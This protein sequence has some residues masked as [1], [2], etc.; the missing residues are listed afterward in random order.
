MAQYSATISQSTF[1]F[2][3]DRQLYKTQIDLTQ[4]E[5]FESV[6]YNATTVKVMRYVAETGTFKDVLFHSEITSTGVMTL[7][8]HEKFNLK[9]LILKDL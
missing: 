7:W 5:G 4:I 2:D 9:V 8:V 6:A 1:A 3:E